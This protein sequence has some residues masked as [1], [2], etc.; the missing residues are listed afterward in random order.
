MNT[1]INNI[2]KNEKLLSDIRLRQKNLHNLSNYL[3]ELESQLALIFAASPDIIVFLDEKAH[4]VKISNAVRTI[5][6]YER[7]EMVNHSIWDYIATEDLEKTKKFFNNVQ[8]KKIVYG[9]NKHCLVNHWIGKNGEKV[10][11]IWRFSVCDEREHHTI[12]VASKHIEKY[13][14]DCEQVA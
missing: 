4:I 6:G 3:S 10:R 8:D 2:L 5:L 7:E 12:G 13:Q 9:G 14:E 11:L 1:S